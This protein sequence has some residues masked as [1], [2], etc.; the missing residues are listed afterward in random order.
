MVSSIF[1]TSVAQSNKVA[2]ITPKNRTKVHQHS[3]AMTYYRLSKTVEKHDIFWPWPEI[4]ALK[5]VNHDLVVD[6]TLHL[7]KVYMV[8]SIACANILYSQAR[9]QVRKNILSQEIM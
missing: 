7:F 1:L 4:K 6:K 8:N 9:L 5:N 2:S 3:S